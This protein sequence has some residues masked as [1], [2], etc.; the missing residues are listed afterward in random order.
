MTDKIEKE[1]ETEKTIDDIPH[2]EWQ[3]MSDDDK[4]ALIKP[5]EDK[6]EPAKEEEKEDPVKA[7]EDIKEEKPDNSA[8]ARMRRAEKEAAELRKKNE[9]R[10]QERKARDSGDPDPEP[11]K[12]DD[13]EAWYEWNLR[14]LNDENKSLKVK[15]D[16][17][18]NFI[19]TALKQENRTKAK[20]ELAEIENDFKKS[21]PDYDDAVRHMASLMFHG[22]KYAD[23][24]KSEK[25]IRDEIETFA[26][27]VA[28]Q[29]YN[30]DQNPAEALYRMAKDHYGFDPKK[31]EKTEEKKPGPNLKV[32]AD[33][34]KRSPS[35]MTASAKSGDYQL[36]Q[37][38]AL[39]LSNAE[40]QALPAA[41]KRRL[42]GRQ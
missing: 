32:V 39:E 30:S 24:F 35:G 23:P 2:A 26:L 31:V 38:A 4:A 33:A 40:F 25:E 41:E 21:A 28:A 7:E 29:A 13:I 8:Y 19:G 20:A 6:E 1:V 17:H 5:E 14:Q 11:N 27:T 9:E 37:E 12:A 16:E 18:D 42:M 22:K 3:G 34:K 10:E 36:S 15:L